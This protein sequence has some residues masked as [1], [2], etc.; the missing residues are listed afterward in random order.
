MKAAI[1]LPDELFHEI[2]ACAREMKTSRSRV[3]AVAARD[4]LDRRRAPAAT[5]EA[6]NRAVA[7]AGQPG[8]EPAA[9]AFRR[10]TKAL[11]RPRT[12]RRA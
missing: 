5:T 10:R 4:F 7:R 9:R 2:E 12:R 3:L 8:D 6:W 1:S 11:L